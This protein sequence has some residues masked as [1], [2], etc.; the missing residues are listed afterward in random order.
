MHTYFHHAHHAAGTPASAVA[1]G[2]VASVVVAAEA[3]QAW[4]D[5]SNQVLPAAQRRAV[6]RKTAGLEPRWPGGFERGFRKR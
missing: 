2:N 4:R 5:F 1:M 3:V 6:I